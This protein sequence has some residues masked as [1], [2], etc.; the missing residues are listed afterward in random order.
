M[1]LEAQLVDKVIDLGINAIPLLVKDDGGHTYHLMRRAR[2]VSVADLSIELKRVAWS[3]LAGQLRKLHEMRGDG[4]GLVIGVDPLK[5]AWEKWTDYLWSNCTQNLEYAVAHDLL[6]A[7]QF[8]EFS[9]RFITWSQM[10]EVPLSFLHGDLNDHN[11]FADP[12]T[13]HLTDIIDWEDALLADP[14]FELASWACFTS[15]PES[16]WEGFFSA[17]Y[18]DEERPVDFW[19]RFY[20]YFLRIS[21]SRL[22]QL[23]KYGFA[24][25]SKAKDRIV[26]AMERLKKL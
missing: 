13:G 7:G 2:G 23:H 20:I 1:N 3:D 17:Y 25:L 8:T 12:Q 10:N 6:A 22:V 16:E 14:I 15:H 9:S 19:H 21:L 11:L 24:Q 18:K 4:A 5:G 26:F